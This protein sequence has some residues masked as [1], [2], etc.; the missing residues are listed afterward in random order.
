VAQQYAP[1]V[2]DGRAYYEPSSHG[3][4]SRFSER[5]RLIRAILHPEQ[6]GGQPAG[7]PAGGAKGDEGKKTE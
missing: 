2:I 5:S 4:E 7:G 3:M 1:D 6:E